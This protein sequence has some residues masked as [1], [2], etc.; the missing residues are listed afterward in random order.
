MSVLRR[1]GETYSLVTRRFGGAET[2]L[3]SRY[4]PVTD[5]VLCFTYPITPNPC[6]LPERACD[7]AMFKQGI[8]IQGR[9]M[10]GFRLHLRS[11][12]AIV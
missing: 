5:L 4:H 6:Y 8:R 2:R 3:E 9:F 11:T 10:F 12:R 7:W 1:E